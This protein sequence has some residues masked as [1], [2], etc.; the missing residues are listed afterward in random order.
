MSD[1]NVILI[2]FSIGSA[3]LFF[4]LAIMDKIFKQDYLRSY[5]L[6]Y[7]FVFISN[8]SIIIYLYTEYIFLITLSLNFSIASGYFLSR[9][10][11]L[12]YKLKLN[13]VN[14]IITLSLIL[15]ISFLSL[16]PNTELINGSLFILGILFYYLFSATIF[17]KH[18]LHREKAMSFL[19]IMMLLLMLIKPYLSEYEKTNIW[20]T[21]IQGYLG[22]VLALYL[23]FIHLYRVEMKNQQQQRDLEYLS[24]HDTL[25][26]VY[27]RT[28][29]NQLLT[30]QM[31]QNEFPLVAVM[32]DMN[33]LKVINDTH[34]HDA[35]DYAIASFASSIKSVVRI[36]DLIIRRS[37][38]EFLLF[39]PNT[40]E[41][42]TKEIIQEIKKQTE[43]FSVEGIFLSISTGY[44]I[45]SNQDE[46]LTKIIELADQAMYREKRE[47]KGY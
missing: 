32:M 43:S 6:L 15:L 44:A 47:Y 36:D 35:G 14:W 39:M 7:F 27:N 29:L 41:L 13:K 24:F 34:G 21:L 8:I 38:D 46:D 25:T 5:S 23:I 18:G 1:I 28:Y 33:N 20:I 31:L 45:M 9:G 26:G 42:K 10:S 16:F 4:V 3:L 40:D 19:L 11:K 30:N 17:Y 37:G 22:L 2:T 12:L